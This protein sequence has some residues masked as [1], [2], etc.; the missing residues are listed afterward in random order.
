MTNKIAIKILEYVLGR[1]SDNMGI[2]LYPN[3]K[4][5]RA[6]IE[7]AIKALEEQ[8][9]D[10]WIPVSERK[11]KMSGHYLVTNNY[12]ELDIGLLLSYGEFISSGKVIAWK[13]LPEPYK[14]NDNET[15][16]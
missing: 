15:D 14:E 9:A 8:E 1:H 7:L 6:S 2:T 3:L 12:G 11:P 13:P 4:E 16:N 10:R 5:E